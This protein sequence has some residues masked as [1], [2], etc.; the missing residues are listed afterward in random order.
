[1]SVIDTINSALSQ[2]EQRHQ[3]RVLYA[4]E[5]GSRAWG[6]ASP[7]SD[8][9]IRFIYLKPL[10]WYL[11][12]GE[13]RDSFEAMLPG[14]LDLAGWELRKT[15]RLYAKGNMALNEWLG[16]PMI[17]REVGP[18]AQRMREGLAQWFQ[19]VQAIHHYLS[20]G[21]RTFEEQL[22]QQERV[23]IKRL[24]YALRPLLC[25]RWIRQHSS[26]PPT[27]LT[28]LI[29]GME[30]SADEQDQI[31]QVMQ[32]KTQA[33]EREL[34]P[35]SGW[36]KRWLEDEIAQAHACDPALPAITRPPIASLDYWL[37]EALHDPDLAFA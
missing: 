25:C 20:M 7:D 13:P 12:V 27:A 36:W 23:A 6:F 8:Y 19:P 34:W 29:A 10:S 4:A 31:E 24:F 2:T 30:I 3:L 17:Y 33:A 28:A 21:R 11:S 26:Q 32:I 16:S 9:D 1:M 15:L 18:L 22:Q 35:I 14:D 37:Q 5:S